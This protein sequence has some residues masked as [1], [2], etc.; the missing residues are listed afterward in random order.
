MVNGELG[1]EEEATGEVGS[2]VSVAGA[3]SCKQALA[4][5]EATSVQ[6]PGTDVDGV[7]QRWLTMVSREVE[8]RAEWEERMARR[9]N[10]RGVYPCPMTRRDNAAAHVGY[11]VHRHRAPHHAVARWPAE[12][13]AR[14]GPGTRFPG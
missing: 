3:S 14:A 11:S 6:I 8:V 9:Q 4:D 2:P 13:W 5:E 10:E 7:W 1:N 12:R